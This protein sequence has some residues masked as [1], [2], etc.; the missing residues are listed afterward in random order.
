MGFV[1]RNKLAV[2][3]KTF[4]NDEDTVIVDIIDR[5]FKLKQFDNKVYSNRTPSSFKY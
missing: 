3:N 5:V 1:D 2:F 4:Y